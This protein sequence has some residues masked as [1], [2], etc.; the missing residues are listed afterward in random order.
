V[1]GAIEP[2]KGGRRIAVL[3]DMLELGAHSRDLHAGLAEPLMAA[4][5]DLVFTVGAEMTALD[6]ALPAAR[7]GGHA[8]TS[9]EMAEIVADRIRPGD[10][11]TNKGSFGS[12]MATVVK[13]LTAGAP[14]L[15]V[16]G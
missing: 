5:V 2:G 9:A 14:A 12:R 8:A 11:V 10:V 4:G 6:G 7:R 15:A 3:G 16:K 13:R 1:L